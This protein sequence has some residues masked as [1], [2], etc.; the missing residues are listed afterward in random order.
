MSSGVGIAASSGR[1]HRADAHDV[2]DEPDAGRLLE[3]P[4][5][6]GA[7]RHAGGRLAG[8]GALEHRPG[9]VEGV[10]AH[11]D[12]VGVPGTRTG[13][14]GV[15]RPQ[16]HVGVLDG[17]RRHHVDPLGP[18]G[19]ADLDRDGTALRAPVPHAAEEPDLVLLELHPRTPAV[20][21][22]PTGERLL[23]VRALHL[24]VGRQAL[25]DADE[26][27]AMGLTGG[28]PTQHE[29]ASFHVVDAD[30]SG[31][32]ARAAARRRDRRPGVAVRAVTRDRD[33][34]VLAAVRDRQRPAA[35]LPGRRVPAEPRRRRWS[36]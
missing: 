18:L 23:D 13:E 10:L 33:Q 36:T 14:R 16:Q 17:V 22:A 19:V 28:Q 24:D 11:A 8:A 26:R 5:R 35:R 4:G 21:E 25:E 29:T 7:E 30:A 20:A 34:R 31:R 12:E 9:V 27:R 15:A 2:R 32:T 1:E 3:E 6:D